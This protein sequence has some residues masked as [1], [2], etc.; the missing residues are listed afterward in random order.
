MKII[1]DINLQSGEISQSIVASVR[2]LLSGMD[3]GPAK[4]PIIL[5]K[6][7]HTAFPRFAERGTGGTFVQQVS[8]HFL[9]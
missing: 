5:L 4:H 8:N 6:M 3:N 7:L 9:I 2:D 1:L